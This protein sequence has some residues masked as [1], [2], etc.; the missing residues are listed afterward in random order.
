MGSDHTAIIMRDQSNFRPQLFFRPRW[1]LKNKN[2][3]EWSKKIEAQTADLPESG[4]TLEEYNSLA[5]LILKTCHAEFS[6]QSSSKPRTPGQPWWN[7]DCA[8]IVAERAAARKR[9]YKFPTPANKTLYNKTSQKAKEIICEAKKISWEKFLSSLGPHTPTTKVWKFFKSMRG[10]A[11][12]SVIPFSNHK[13]EP[14]NAEQSAEMLAQHYRKNFCNV[15]TLQSKLNSYIELATQDPTDYEYNRP[16][17]LHELNKEIDT[18]RTKSSMGKDLIHNHFLVHLPNPTRLKLLNIFNKIFEEGNIP[19]DWKIAD[20][21][22]IQKPGKDPANPAAYRPI[23]LLSCA[24]KLMERIISRRLKWYTET[25]NILSP[26]QFGF[27]TNRSTLDPLAVLEHEIQICYRR[28]Q[29]TTVAIIDL[30]AAFDRADFKAIGYKLAKNGIRG[31]MLSWILN[32]L[33][34]RSYRVWVQ[35]KASQIYPISSSVP[36]GSPLS[37]SLFNY[38]LLDIPHAKADILIYADDITLY[39]TKETLEE[40]M[41]TLQEAINEIA[42]WCSENGQEVNAQKSAYTF[43]TRKRIKPD[44]PLKLGNEVIKYQKEVKILG[45]TLDS[46]HL[47]WKPHIQKTIIKCNKRLNIMKCFAGAT[48]GISRDL[49]KTYYEAHI[50]S[51]MNYG[52]PIFTSA[53]PSSLAK[54]TIIH[55]S[56]ARLITGAWKCTPIQALYAEARILP[57]DIQSELTCA[58]FLAKLLSSPSDHPIQKLFIRDNWLDYTGLS[59]KQYKTPLYYRVKHSHL[60]RN[61]NSKFDM[62]KPPADDCLPPWINLKN[63]IYPISLEPELSKSSNNNITIFKDLV[64]RH[65]PDTTTIFTDGSL[66][67]EEGFQVGAS[68]FNYTNNLKYKWKL[69]SHHSILSA[70]LFALQ[71]AT[72]NHASNNKPVIIFTDSQASLALLSNHQPKTYKHS[73]HA[74]QQTLSK[75]KS[76]IQ[77]HW[78]PGHSGIKG[79]EIADQLAKEAAQSSTH[80]FPHCTETPEI[81]AIFKRESLSSWDK[82]WDLIKGSTHLGRTLP[83]IAHKLKSQNSSRKMEVIFAQLRLGHSRLNSPLY[84]IKQAESPN[85]ANCPA[86]ET[87]THFLLI[88]PKYKQQRYTLACK[89]KDLNIQL[90]LESLLSNPC[91]TKETEKYILATRRFE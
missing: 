1:T 11:P 63:Y 18:L 28:Q 83:K 37:P 9:F 71:K 44:I 42:K 53:A 40:A 86:E 59:G 54:L 78:V 46:P 69:D 21:I 90:N 65:F 60:T 43:F 27:R 84:K 87:V 85:C 2:F 22:P 17:K 24:G 34:G 68:M 48:A 50:K 77:I 72:K 49:L 47:T 57:P 26:H 4:N 64:N 14:Q 12:I 66:L 5:E 45:L 52:L 3:S 29:I 88:C 23:S 15:N 61:H 75:A 36:Q 82:R 35:N 19:N 25:N 10:K 33:Q 7:N 81:K 39:S 41:S 73:I 62:L 79:N 70:E 8:N 30:S 74:I 76:K 67:K 20:I 80:I 32:Y 31:K 55:N 6:L 91:A 56:A 58:N 13:D 38:L 51:L 16:F 89:L